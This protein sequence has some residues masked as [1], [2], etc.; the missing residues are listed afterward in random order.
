MTTGQ[1]AGGPRGGVGLWNRLRDLHPLALLL[2]AA[3]VGL[4]ITWLGLNDWRLSGAYRPSQTSTLVGMTTETTTGG[5]GPSGSEAARVLSGSSPVKVTWLGQGEALKVT[6]GDMSYPDLDHY[7]VDVYGVAPE[8]TWY[9]VGY[10]EDTK[11]ASTRTIHPLAET[12]VRYAETDKPTAVGPDETWRICATGMRR[13]PAGAAVS[14][15]EIDGSKKC[16]DPFVVP[17]H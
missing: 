13:V 1:H 4:M 17:R 15:Y 14:P 16:S 7:S 10:R 2:L 12:R 3:I 9:N 11:L 6:W 8:Q 5:P